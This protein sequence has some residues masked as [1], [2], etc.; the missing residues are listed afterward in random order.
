MVRPMHAVS[1]RQV[2]TIGELRR[3][4]AAELVAQPEKMRGDIP[5]PD[6]DARLL[7]AAAAGLDASALVLAE[8]KAAPPTVVERALAFAARR[9]GGEPVARILGRKEFWG[10][11]FLLSDATL[12]PRP[13]TETVVEAALAHARKRSRAAGPLRVLDLGTGTGAIL[14]ALLSELPAATAIGA[15]ISLAAIDTARTNAERLGVATRARFIVSDW[16]AAIGTDARFDLVVANPPYIPT[17]AIGELAV[18]VRD[19][20]PLPAL[21][22]GSDGLAAIRAILADLPRLLA[23]DAAAFL[24][25]GAGQRGAVARLAIGAGFAPE[26]VADLAGIDRVAV[27]RH[28]KI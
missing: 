17:D 13:D 5:T 28:G 3:A 11:D 26:F 4:V 12:V 24:E 9:R 27:L 18:E 14:I 25:L 20:D 21:D 10:L 8:G 7:T 16:G 23:V 1:P 22:G 6:L 15:D 2:R 19:H